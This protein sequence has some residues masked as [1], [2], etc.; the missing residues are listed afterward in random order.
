MRG[1][2][3]T[4]P[5]K[6]IVVMELAELGSLRDLL[7]GAH[8][9]EATPEWRLQV[10]L[11]VAHGMK[12]IHASGDSL[13]RDLKSMNVLVFKDGRAKVA[14]FGRAKKKSVSATATVGG[15]VGTCFA[16]FCFCFLHRDPVNII[17]NVM[18]C[19]RIR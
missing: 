12:A 2:C 9:W 1:A 10:L 8:G 17:A 11:D 13:H 3:T 5:G 7:D 14:D 16:F 4:E 6:L 19:A 15:N 18:L